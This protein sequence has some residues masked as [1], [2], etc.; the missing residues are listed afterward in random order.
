MRGGNCPLAVR[1]PVVLMGVLDMLTCESV[2]G[3]ERRPVAGRIPKIGFCQE[4]KRLQQEFL[5][6]I[7]E[8]NELQ[9]QQ[10][11]A[12]IDG[13]PDFN[14]FDILLHMAL[15]RKE[16]AKY[17]WIAHVEAHHCEEV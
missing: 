8:F 12:V 16:R 13:D 14:R 3:Q 11:Q 1:L 4:K 2:M 10:I 7:H 17:A 6:A 5:R 15:E 9:S